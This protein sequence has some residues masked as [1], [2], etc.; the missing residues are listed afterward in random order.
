MAGISC[1]S[2]TRLGAG[3]GNGS[4]CLENEYDGKGRITKH[5]VSEG[6]LPDLRMGWTL[7]DIWEMRSIGKLYIQILAEELDNMVLSCFLMKEY[8]NIHTGKR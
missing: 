6:S 7:S 4:I 5:G 8:G 1:R 2:R 3:S